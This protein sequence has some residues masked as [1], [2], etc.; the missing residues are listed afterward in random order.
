M[1]YPNNLYHDDAVLISTFGGILSKCSERE[2][3]FNN[4]SAKDAKVSDIVLEDSQEIG[5]S[6]VLLECGTYVFE[7]EDKRVR[8]RFSMISDSEG[9]MHHHSSVF[10]SA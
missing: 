10:A 8:A 9:I 5:N 4:L 1:G 7:Y 2:A 6:R 3:Y